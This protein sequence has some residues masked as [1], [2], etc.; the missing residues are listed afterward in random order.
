[1]GKC[2]SKQHLHTRILSL[3]RC[4]ETLGLMKEVSPLLKEIEQMR[5]TTSE[6]EIFGYQVKV[7]YHV[8]T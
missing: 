6:I 3:A 1:M 8:E 7:R 5:H 4:K 2:Q